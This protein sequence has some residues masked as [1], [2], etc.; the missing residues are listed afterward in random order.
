VPDEHV[1]EVI[2]FETDDPAM[3]G[4]MTITFTLTDAGGGTDVTAIHDHLP[5]GLSPADNELGWQM[6]LAKLATLVETS[7][8]E[9]QSV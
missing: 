1:V 2:E 9:T 4:E 8:S 5:P 3:R 7:S 6:S